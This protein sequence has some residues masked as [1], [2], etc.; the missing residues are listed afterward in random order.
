MAE[1]CGFSDQNWVGLCKQAPNNNDQGAR[2]LRG[3]LPN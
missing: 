2:A 3:F 1:H